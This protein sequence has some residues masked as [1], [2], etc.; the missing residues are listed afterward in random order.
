[1]QQHPSFDPL[2]GFSNVFKQQQVCQRKATL[3]QLTFHRNDTNQIE[4]IFTERVT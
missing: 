4:I 1:M 2:I 3:T